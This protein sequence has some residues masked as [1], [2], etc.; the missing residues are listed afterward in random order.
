MASIEK[1]A[2]GEYRARVKRKGVR[3]SKTFVL[4][5]DAAA[6]AK[7]REDEIDRQA[8]RTLGE[9]R[10]LGDALK[11]YA[12][13]VSPTHKGER[14]EQIRLKAM[15]A[16]LPITLPLARVTHEH[17]ARWR[18]AR[19]AAVGPDSVRREMALLGSV[20]THARRDWRWIADSPMSDV[21]RPKAS[22]H[23]SRVM[24]WRELRAILRTLRH[25]RGRPTTMKSIVALALLLA[26]R[27]GMRAGELTG[28]RWA[29]VG[30]HGVRLPDTKNGSAR[31]VPL[32]RKAMQL[33][34]RARGLDDVLVLP[35]GTQTLDALFRA[36][37]DAAGIEGLRWHDSRH[38]AATR[39]GATVGQPGRLSFPEFVAMFGWRDPRN[40]MVYVNPSAAALAGKLD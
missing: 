40:A 19:A 24:T 15:E 29:L 20:L 25:R 7:H 18:D 21:R 2:S 35:V 3:D 8:D 17:L 34:E 33:V 14:W 12:A 39:I 16:Q 13:E 11:R 10:T 4:R 6:W 9:V 38:T 22:P 5:R 30:S 26:L 31:E 32:S 27:T 37:R 36:A 28:M 1:T 23:R